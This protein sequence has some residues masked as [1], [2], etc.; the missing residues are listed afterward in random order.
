MLRCVCLWI[1]V[2]YFVVPPRVALFLH[3]VAR[4]FTFQR[5][6]LFVELID[7]LKQKFKFPAARQTAEQIPSALSLSL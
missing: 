4:V 1:C 6:Q 7:A 5:A 2:V 3:G